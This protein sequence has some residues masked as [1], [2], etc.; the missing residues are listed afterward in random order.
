MGVSVIQNTPFPSAKSPPGIFWMRAFRW[1]GKNNLIWREMMR[2]G[3]F[4]CK[5]EDFRLRNALCEAM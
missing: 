2:S 4:F 3:Y 5:E 1:F